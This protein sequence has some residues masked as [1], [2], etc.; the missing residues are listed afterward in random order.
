M[1]HHNNSP[2][3]AYD[4]YNPASDILHTLAH[5]FFDKSLLSDNI[6]VCEIIRTGLIV[7]ISW[8]TCHYI[9]WHIINIMSQNVALLRLLICNH[10]WLHIR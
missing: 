5:I 8:M 2:Q 6:L 10:M 3:D 1:E 4:A 9:W 7:R